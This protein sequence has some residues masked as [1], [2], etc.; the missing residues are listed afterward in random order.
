MF[1]SKSGTTEKFAEKKF[2]KFC[3]NNLKE[4]T[5]VMT[6]ILH[7]LVAPT[8]CFECHGRLFHLLH[9]VSAQREARRFITEG[10]LSSEFTSHGLYGESIVRMTVDS[11]LWVKRSISLSILTF[12]LRLI[13]EGGFSLRVA[14]KLNYIFQIQIRFFT[15]KLRG[16]QPWTYGILSL[17]NSEEM[18]K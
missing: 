13:G 4:Q 17:N 15:S 18:L 11:G 9:T 14:W 12:K 5:I 8:R 6:K 16:L 1:V 3:F 10:G 7:V 2:I